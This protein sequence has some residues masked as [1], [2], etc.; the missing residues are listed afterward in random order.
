MRVNRS[1]ILAL[2]FGFGDARIRVV[3]LAVSWFWRK[4]DGDLPSGDTVEE[5]YRLSDGCIG[6]FAKI[7]S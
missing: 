6:F 7:V 1:Y 2:C 5:C 4:I 3:T